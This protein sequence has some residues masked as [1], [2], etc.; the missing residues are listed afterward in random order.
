MTLKK[1][2][3]K[4]YKGLPVH[5]RL[6]AGRR[7]VGRIVSCALLSPPANWAYSRDGKRIL[8]RETRAYCRQRLG[9]PIWVA[10]LI[11]VVVPI[12]VELIWRWWQS[13]HNAGLIVTY[14]LCRLHRA[15]ARDL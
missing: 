8:L 9:N 2:Q 6:L 5:A 3:A 11:Q 13:Q 12:V 4:I 14:E 7:Q 10:I 15:A 1:L